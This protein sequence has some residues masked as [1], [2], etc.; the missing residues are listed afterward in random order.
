MLSAAFLDSDRPVAAQ[1]ENHRVRLGRALP[2]FRARQHPRDGK[3]PFEGIIFRT[4]EFDHV[5]DVRPWNKA[6][7][8]PQLDTLAQIKW[9]KFTDNLLTLYAANQWKMDWFNDEQWK[10][11]VENMK[12]FSLAVE[13][14]NCIGV[15]FDPEPY[16]ENPWAYPGSYKDKS[17]AQVSEQVR[18]RGQQFIAALQEHKSEIKVLSFFFI[19]LFPDVV[20]VPDP[21]VRMQRLQRNS[22]ALLPA[23]CVGMLEGA[24]PGTV[25]IDGNESAYYH[26]SPLDFYVDYHLMGQRPRPCPRGAAQKIQQRTCRPAW[27]C[28]SIRHSPNAPTARSRATS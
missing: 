2:G 21:N 15:C 22:Y 10:T 8:Q 3:R 24:S 9:G 11:I 26:E 16:G 13:T 14:G 7:L 19:A 27:C 5:F 20:D 1:E 12:L 17:F 28:T 25:L 4:Q 23:F 18:R 6:D